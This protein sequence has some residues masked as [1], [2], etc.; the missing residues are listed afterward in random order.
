MITALY[1]DHKDKGLK[2]PEPGQTS[3]ID[4]SIVVALGPAETTGKIT[5][6]LN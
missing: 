1:T 3:E 5:N 4:S 2:N 6:L